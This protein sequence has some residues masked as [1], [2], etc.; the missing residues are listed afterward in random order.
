MDKKTGNW[1]DTLAYGDLL[2]GSLDLVSRLSN[3]KYRAYNKRLLGIRGRFTK[4]KDHPSRR[5]YGLGI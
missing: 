1:D 4:S 5:D 3:R 2:R